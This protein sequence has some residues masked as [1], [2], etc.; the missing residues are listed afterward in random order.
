MILGRKK[1]KSDKSVESCPVQVL[2]EQEYTIFQFFTKLQT[3]TTKCI[4]LVL[5]ARQTK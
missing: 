4:F 5:L 1:K 3:V 2:S